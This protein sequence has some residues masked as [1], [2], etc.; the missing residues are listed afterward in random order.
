MLGAFGDVDEPPR[1]RMLVSEHGLQ[2]RRDHFGEVR[3]RND[4]RH[5]Q[6]GITHG[7]AIGRD[8]PQRPAGMNAPF[9][10]A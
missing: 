2:S 1:P 5:E 10:F 8:T 9:A 7:H 6:P 4:Q 3:L